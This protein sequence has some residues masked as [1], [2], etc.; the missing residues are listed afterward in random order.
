MVQSLVV[1]RLGKGKKVTTMLRR[2]SSR[3]LGTPEVIKVPAFTGNKMPS[4]SLEGEQ[5]PD[6][7][8]PTQIASDPS[9][10][11]TNRKYKTRGAS[12]IKKVPLH[13]RINQFS[14]QYLSVRGHTINCTACTGSPHIRLEYE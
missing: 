10:K 1:I 14:G 8:K 5:L 13:V 11:K 12:D 3:G 9:L 7:R 2:W 4:S 6:R